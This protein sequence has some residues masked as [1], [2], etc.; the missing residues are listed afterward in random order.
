MTNLIE[1]I[2]D[3]IDPSAEMPYGAAAARVRAVISEIEA[4][5]YRVVPVEPTKAMI[6]AAM[7]SDRDL[8]GLTY[9][10]MLAAAPKVTP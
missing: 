5:G 8:V 10:A 6:A 9:T 2:M 7:E 1:A 3:A 4:A